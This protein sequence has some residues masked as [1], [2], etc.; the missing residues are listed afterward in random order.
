M[1]SKVATHAL[2]QNIDFKNNPTL[3]IALIWLLIYKKSA[4]SSS[5][6]LDENKPICP[7]KAF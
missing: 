3:F 2:W 6:R 1:N 4:T 5:L 7:S